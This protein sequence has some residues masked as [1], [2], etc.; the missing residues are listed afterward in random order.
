MKSVGIKYT[1]DEKAGG[2]A[3]QNNFARYRNCT[4]IAKSENFAMHCQF[5]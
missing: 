3:M 5:C 1:K 2:F 4:E